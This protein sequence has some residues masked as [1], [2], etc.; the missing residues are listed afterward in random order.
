[1]FRTTAFI[2]GSEKRV[3]FTEFKTEIPMADRICSAPL[4]RKGA[5]DNWGSGIAT[6]LN[7]YCVFPGEISVEKE[8]DHHGPCNQQSMVMIESRL[9]ELYLRKRDDLKV[10]GLMYIVFRPMKSEELKTMPKECIPAILPS[11]RRIKLSP[12]DAALEKELHELSK[13]TEL[14]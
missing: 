12:E 9:R 11:R 1:M 14:K 4:V 10:H 6:K 2:I 8:W 13:Q 3:Y 7:Q 5:W